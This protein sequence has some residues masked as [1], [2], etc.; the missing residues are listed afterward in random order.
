MTNL[1]IGGIDPRTTS[2]C[3]LRDDSRWFGGASGYGRN[4]GRPH[5]HD[6]FIEHASGSTR[7]R[8]PVSRAPLCIPHWLRR[9]GKYRGG[10]GLI[11]EIELLGPRRSLCWRTGA[12][13][14]PMGWRAEAKAQM[15]ARCSD[16][17][18][19][20]R[21]RGQVQLRGAGW[22][23]DCELRLLAVAVGVYDSC[24]ILCRSL[25]P[26]FGSPAPGDRVGLPSR[27]L[28]RS[29]APLSKRGNKRDGNAP[30]SPKDNLKI[31]KL[32][33]FLVKPRWLFLKIH[34]N[35]GI[36]GLGEPITEGRALTCAEA[37][38]EIEPY[39]VGKIPAG[40]KALAGH[41]PARFL[42]RRSYTHERSAASIRRSGISKARR[43]AFPSTNSR[44]PHARPR[45]R[46]RA[47]RP[48][49]PDESAR[50]RASPHSKPASRRSALPATS[51]RRRK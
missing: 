29:P 24:Q 25:I 39:L 27:R 43:S 15:A 33:T 36:V 48:A 42:S 35:A 31:T 40:G 18:Q 4:F 37:V 49:G 50:P 32:E 7:V 34:T 2:L 26:N 3:L 21:A 44:W 20:N 23:R 10:D 41:L 13:S 28:A 12:F 14:R 1:T 45:A 8:V 11:R 51:K 47:R 5:P 16:E 30:I 19:G 17:R 6:E 22:S 9:P 38:K 46:L